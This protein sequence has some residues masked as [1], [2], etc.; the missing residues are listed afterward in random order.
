[1]VASLLEPVQRAIEEQGRCNEQKDIAMPAVAEH[2]VAP[3]VQ[4]VA[5]SVQP[6]ATAVQP[7]APPLPAS[8]AVPDFS[9]M[10]MPALV[11]QVALLE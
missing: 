10:V 11:F 9:A 8:R 4:P 1:M 2:L 7:V 6:V 5:A 3:A